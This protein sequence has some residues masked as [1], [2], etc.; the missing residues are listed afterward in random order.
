MASGSQEDTQPQKQLVEEHWS[1]MNPVP[2]VQ[3]FT[4]R[5]DRENRARNSQ[6]DEDDRANRLRAAK[7]KGKDKGGEQHE[8]KHEDVASHHARNV[9][10]AKIRTVTDPT[11]SKEIGVEDQDETAMDAAM[12]PKVHILFAC[13]MRIVD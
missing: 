7:E 10:R 8:G 2:I 5:L 9:S 11:T 12:D 1:G 6:I 13:H 3:K 4:E